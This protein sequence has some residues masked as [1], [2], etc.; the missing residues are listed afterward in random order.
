LFVSSPLFGIYW[1]SG[2]INK[3]FTKNI[4]SMSTTHSGYNLLAGG[5]TPIIPEIEYMPYSFTFNRVPQVAKN[6]DK[7]AYE[8]CTCRPQIQV[9]G[10]SMHGRRILSEGFELVEYVHDS[11]DPAKPQFI[12]YIA[13]SAYT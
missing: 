1:S 3:V 8:V 4:T 10:G 9:E 13:A 2:T 7:P 11:T 5:A 6:E 12:L